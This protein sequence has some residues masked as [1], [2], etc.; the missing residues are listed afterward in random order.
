MENKKKNDTQNNNFWKVY[1]IM[2][3]LHNRLKSMIINKVLNEHRNELKLFAAEDK[4]RRDSIT[5]FAQTLSSKP[6]HRM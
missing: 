1:K 3:I 4:K 6:L 5:Q 2:L